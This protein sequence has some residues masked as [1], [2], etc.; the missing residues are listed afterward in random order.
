M[1][2]SELE[3]IM[4]EN[5]INTLADIARVLSTTPQAVSNWKARN[6]VPYHIVSK[7]NKTMMFSDEPQS[8]GFGNIPSHRSIKNFE[9]ETIS[10]SD[11]LMT[12]AEQL[13]VI[14]LIPFVMVFLTFTYVQFIQKPLYTS[15]AKVLLPPSATPNMGGLAGIASQFG[16]NMPT[17]TSADLSSP[18][19][20]PELLRSRTFAEQILDKKFYTKK[21]DKE[22]TLLEILSNG[23]LSP[24]YGRDTL[25]T[26]A[27][28]SLQS[29]LEFK[30]DGAFSI[31]E[32]TTFEPIF[33]KELAKVT[34]SELE[35][36][37]QFFKSQS[38]YEKTIFIE[39]RVASVK[40]DLA[41]SEQKLKIFREQNRQVS[42]P[43]LQLEFERL[44]RNVEIQKGIYLTLRQQLE[45]AK[46]EE[47]QESS[48]IQILDTPQIPL[49]SFNKN[50]KKNVFISGLLGIII[51]I[52]VGFAR[53]YADNPDIGERK[54]LRRVKFLFIKKTKDLYKD[55]RISGTVTFLMLFGLPF[56]LGYKSIEPVFFGM[57]SVRLMFINTVYVFTFII[58]LILFLSQIK[59]NR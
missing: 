23:E 22:L 51:G 30:Q 15:W 33:A 49:S 28:S 6:Q 59:K 24:S 13:K 2:F 27:M 52:I 29:M 54:K 10:F 44:T 38:L 3:A 34:L 18:T 12:M 20:F 47:V 4:Y 16:V 42:S 35:K 53:A 57:Y 39:Q 36:L 41:S 58:A 5:D 21:F 48:I 8:A 17:T 32:A 37:N 31:L 45:L 14:V 1:K 40:A 50:I 55:P 9:E 25:V 56:F 11:L 26:N 46:I 7:I 43:A 19:L